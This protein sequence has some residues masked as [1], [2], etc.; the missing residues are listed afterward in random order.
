MAA[1]ESPTSATV[2]ADAVS[3]EAHSSWPTSRQEHTHPLTKAAGLSAGAA[4]SDGS[5][6]SG[7]ARGL[8]AAATASR[9][10]AKAST[11]ATTRLARADRRRPAANRPGFSTRCSV[12]PASPAATTTAASRPGS[13]A[14]RPSSGGSRSNTGQCQRY[15]EYD[16][17]PTPRIAGRHN[18][19]PTPSPLVTLPLPI[20]SAVPS[21]GS[22][23]AVPG[24]G[25]LGPNCVQVT[26]SSASPPQPATAAGNSGSRR[27]C[28]IDSAT[29]PPAAS[30]QARVGSE[31]NAHGGDVRVHRAA[32]ASDAAAT[33]PSATAYGAVP[34]AAPGRRSRPS[35]KAVPIISTGHTRG[36]SGAR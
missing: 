15:H 16:T 3:P 36:R 19:R 23:A 9:A 22:S 32:A 25:V 27:Q 5:R 34:A 1:C 11:T 26:R 7:T 24:N 35:R 18:N 6:F 10:W 4:A 17:R 12:S 21:T 29:R 13:P 30:S 28:R 20:T 14:G 31:K 8:A 2:V 33:S